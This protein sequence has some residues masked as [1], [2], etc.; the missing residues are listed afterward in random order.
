VSLTPAGTSRR[1]AT[2][3]TPAACLLP[4]VRRHPRGPTRFG[5]PREPGSPMPPVERRLV[6]DP[7][8]GQ[9]APRRGVLGRA[10][11]TTM[12]FP[13]RMLD[14]A[15]GRSSDV[16]ESHRCV[17]QSPAS[18]VKRASGVVSR[19]RFGAGVPPATHICCAA[20]WPTGQ[21][22]GR[23][24]SRNASS[25]RAKPPRRRAVGS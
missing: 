10:T 5:Q 25:R 23:G 7:A 18:E 4:C 3:T 12:E 14:S 20:V 1:S 16:M 8:S 2:H 15:K 19:G 17:R 24:A 13:R 6:G 11:R 9:N 21:V 22:S